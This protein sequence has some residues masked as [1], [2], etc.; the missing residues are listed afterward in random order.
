[1]NDSEE[2]KGWEVYRSRR[3]KRHDKDEKKFFSNQERA[4]NE[5]SSSIPGAIYINNSDKRKDYKKYNPNQTSFLG[6]NINK[7]AEKRHRYRQNKKE[8]INTEV[9]NNEGSPKIIITDV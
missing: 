5:M 3:Q 6:G 1:M 7:K 4:I 2:N 8:R 9:T